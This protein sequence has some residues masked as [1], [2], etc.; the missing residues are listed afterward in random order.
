M[1][2]LNIILARLVDGLL[3]AF[4]DQPPLVGLAVVSLIVAIAMLTVVRAASNQP[5]LIA[6]KR[7]LQACV[8]EV[9]LFNDDAVAMLRA[10]GE[11]V[12]H[13]LTYLRLSMV[14]VL[15]MIVPLGLLVAQLQFH[16]GYDGLEVGQQALVKVRVR[17]MAGEPPTMTAPPG[18]RIET[19]A[20]WIPSLREAAWRIAPEQPGDY[21]LTVQAGGQVFT[22]TVRVS[23]STAI[24]RRSPLR[25]D[26]GFVNQLLYPAEP[27]LPDG[28]QVESIAVTYPRRDV[29]VL[30]RGVH[31]IVVFFALSMVFAL[32]LRRRFNVVL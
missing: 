32:A 19:P 28:A 9:R 16:Y 17:N 30:G 20:V 13:N 1:S 12:R 11:M 4:E 5:R 10:V 15:W 29:S 23:S 2:V 18:I 25:T 6:V 7:S 3:F 31:W 21:E 26:A 14:P 22:K 27:P 24:V 8:F